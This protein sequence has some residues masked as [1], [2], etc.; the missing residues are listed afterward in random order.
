MKRSGKGHRS[1][2]A[3][4]R[5]DRRIELHTGESAKNATWKQILG[6]ERCGA[7]DSPSENLRRIYGAAGAWEVKAFI[8]TDMEEDDS[9]KSLRDTRGTESKVWA[10]YKE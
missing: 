4:A 7:T 1:I 8:E 2:V 9:R 10:A 6:L 3:D 5:S